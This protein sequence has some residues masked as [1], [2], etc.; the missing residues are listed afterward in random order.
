MYYRTLFQENITSAKKVWQCINKIINTHSNKH[1]VTEII[2]ND[3]VIKK[4]EEI[5]KIFNDYFSTCVTVDKN[6]PEIESNFSLY[7]SQINSKSFFLEQID[8]S[9][10]LNCAKNMKCS[11]SFGHDGVSS[12]F[13][14]NTINNIIVPLSHIFNTSF[15]YGIFPK[16]FK[17]SKIKPLYKKGDRNVIC[18]YRPISLLPTLSKLLEK[19]MFKR[20][21][22]YL[23][24]LNFFTD[25][26]YGFRTNRSTDLALLEITE[27]IL[28]G[29]EDK[30]VTIGL[31]LDLSKAFDSINHDILLK[32]LHC[33][34]IRGVQHDWFK[35]YLF[36][37]NQYVSIGTNHS[38]NVS[39]KYGV[40]QGSVLGPL[41]FNIF[42]N[43]LSYVSKSIKTI[44]FADDTTFLCSGPKINDVA[45][46]LNSELSKILKWFNDNH[47]S[48]NYTKTNY[49]VFGPKIVT[50]RLNSSIFIN[51]I[52]I[53]RVSINKFLG[54]MLSDNLSWLDHILYISTKISK[55]SGMLFKIRF[56]LTVDI[57]KKIYYSL[58]Y[59]YLTYGVILWGKSSISHL[60][61]LNLA[62]NYFVRCLYSLKKYDHI[63]NY[64]A[65][66]KLLNL[67]QIYELYSLKF[68][69]KVNKNLLP[70]N[71]SIYFQN[72]K[73]NYKNLRH[74]KDYIKPFPRLLALRTSIFSMGVSLWNDLPSKYKL[75]NNINLFVKYIKFFL[76][77]NN[78]P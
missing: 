39:I 27:N 31:F 78:N 11:H 16:H 2:Y 3:N 55:I 43:D 58:I 32:K 10:I 20:L 24:H 73:M 36:D 45:K 68:M 25:S 42:I 23:N 72:S 38:P 21:N 69:Y 77:S 22:N 48:I 57:M 14:K 40:P 26:Q 63:S 37:R 62:Y 56:K 28:K 44:L 15:K 65:V 71:F 35:S 67:N 53:E 13:I 6:F 47:L 66:A 30:L 41:L 9:E 18:N 76:L 61:H 33:I 7:Q 12:F 75:I 59:P 60:K 70:S 74:W 8:I 5:C 50:N 51:N 4:P 54:F 1:D 29:M 64:Y 49:M 46:T 34:G 52:A 19:I 17:I